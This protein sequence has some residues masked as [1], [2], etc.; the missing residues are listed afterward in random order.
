MSRTPLL[1]DAQLKRLGRHG[2]RL[3]NLL[4][5]QPAG[6]DAFE[7]AYGVPDLGIVGSTMVTTTAMLDML[8]DEWLEVAILQV[9][10]M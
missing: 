1:E 6:S 8:K 10:S 9:F 5:H 3:H 4:M 2:V 7:I